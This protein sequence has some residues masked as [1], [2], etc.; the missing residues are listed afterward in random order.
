ML[1]MK[2]NLIPILAMGILLESWGIG[3]FILVIGFE[4]KSQPKYKMIAFFRGIDNWGTAIFLNF[5]FLFSAIM[6]FYL[7]GVSIIKSIK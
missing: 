2:I 5:W 1:I 4:K 3:L 7:F 6:S